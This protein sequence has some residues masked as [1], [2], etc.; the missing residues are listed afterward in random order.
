MSSTLILPDGPIRTIRKWENTAGPERISWEVITNIRILEFTG[1]IENWLSSL[2]SLDSFEELPEFLSKL[3]H[4]G[5]NRSIPSEFEIYSNRQI[6]N[7]SRKGIDNIVQLEFS[8]NAQR[9]EVIRSYRNMIYPSTRIVFSKSLILPIITLCCFQVSKLYIRLSNIM[10]IDD[11]LMMWNI[12]S[13]DRIDSSIWIDEPEN[14]LGE[15]YRDS[16][17]DNDEKSSKSKNGDFC[18]GHS[19]DIREWRLERSHDYST[20]KCPYS[21]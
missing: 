9:I 21:S 12:D 3:Y 8:R 19:N 11:S 15:K 17:A 4:T 6:E 18:D 1:E 13:S 10:P 7:L 16:Y 14:T 2:K 20:S 5:T